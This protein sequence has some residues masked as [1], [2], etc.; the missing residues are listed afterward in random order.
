MH[1]TDKKS[2]IVSVLLVLSLLL[3]GVS[4]A[5]GFDREAPH[6]QAGE[7]PTDYVVARVYFADKADLDQLAAYLDIWDVD[8]EQGYLVAMLS[9]SRYAQLEGAGY[10]LEIDQER[11]DLLYNPAEALPGQIDGIPGYSCYRT[12]EETYTSLDT[13]EATYPDL[14]EKINIG[15]SWDYLNMGGPAGYNLYALRI[16]NETIGDIDTKPVFFLMAEIHAREYVTAETATRYAEL[17]LSSYGIDPDITWLL[18]YYKI[19]IVTMTNPD[20]RKFAEGGEWWRKNTD[21]LAGGGCGYPDYGIDLNRNHSF[22]WGG[23]GTNPCGETYQGPSAA[24]EPETQAIQNFVL[25]IMQ[26]QRGPGDTDPAPADT[27][28]LF[29]T[30]HSYGEWML[31]PW[32]WTGT[33][34]PNHAQLRTLG[35]RLAYFN[36]H[37]PMQSNDL[38]GTTGT[39]DDWAYGTLGV[40][41]YTFEMGTNFFQGCT[42][43][44]ST[45]WPDNRDSL[46]WA[47]KATR[48]P[49]MD[50]SGPRVLN[51][52][53]TPGTVDPGDPVALTATANDGLYNNQNGTEPTQNIAAARYSIDAPSWIT[54]TV[55]YDMT[56]SDG[57]FNGTIEGIQA[58]VDTSGLSGGQHIIYVEARDT[59]LTWGVPTAVFLNVNEVPNFGV[60]LDPPVAAL[61]GIPGETVV[62]TL[63]VSNIGAFD[64]TYDVTV[65]SLWDFTAASTV[66]PLTP[67]NSAELL[68][69]VTIP[70]D[71]APGQSDMAE[72][73]V[74]SQ[75]DSAFSD[76]SQLTS[77]AET[78][79]GVLVEVDED[80]LTAYAS[81]TWVTYALTLTN[82]GL[83]TDTYTVSAVSPWEV[84]F[85]T[86]LGPLAPGEQVAFSVAVHVPA[87]TFSG[88][89]NDAILTFASQG[90]PTQT[91]DITLHTLTAWLNAY[92]PMLS[93]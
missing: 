69:S 60:Q 22:H 88:A 92:L 65:S 51:V 18:D 45:I 62:Y 68:V 67:G 27:T 21:N 79:Y 46:L 49:Y 28:G 91:Q 72:V 59:N 54:G 42:S 38:Y 47:F 61:S 26:D 82:S 33:D 31:W 74:T 41:S 75:G 90:D 78:V 63:T 7:I 10:S 5:F 56:A 25:T 16:T 71:A 19:Y 39:S 58:T 32:G 15:Y 43:F 44:E 81:D 57:N 12:V 14:V 48:L 85:D 36:D 24:S 84:T 4:T 86:P 29:I 50:P 13:M 9:P 87:G 76:T 53:A 1:F 6:I 89:S 40:A 11:T 70:T 66:G 52:V 55:T 73:T 34:A 2:K 17:L 23:A 3:G 83:V 93:K 77:T 35:R 30:L 37:W 8:H 64:D 20:G 80:T